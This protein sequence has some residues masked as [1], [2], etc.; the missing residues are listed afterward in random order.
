MLAHIQ[1]HNLRQ[2]LLDGAE[3][4]DANTIREAI[5][6]LSD[7]QL[8]RRFARLLTQGNQTRSDDNP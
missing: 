8:A 5:G 2:W 1:H 3:R 7:G 6:R 4:E